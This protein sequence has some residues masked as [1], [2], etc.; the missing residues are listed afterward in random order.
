MSTQLGAWK[1][2]VKPLLREFV[3]AEQR[4]VFGGVLISALFAVMQIILWGA[5]LASS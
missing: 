3:R 1:L 5:A 2:A 4:I